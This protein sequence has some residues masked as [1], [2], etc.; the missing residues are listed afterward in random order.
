MR[1][2]GKRQ[3]RFFDLRDVECTVGGLPP[4]IYSIDVPFHTTPSRVQNYTEKGR[5]TTEARRREDPTL[6]DSTIPVYA[7]R[8]CKPVAN[9]VKPVKT[10]LPEE[11]RI[12]RRQHRDPLQGLPALPTHPP[13]FTPGERYTQERYEVQAEGMGDFLW[14]E[15]KKLAHWVIREQEGALAWDETEKG[16]FREEY[17]DPIVIPT[18]E[19]IPWVHKNIPIPPGIYDEV[20]RII[21]DKIASGVYEESNA[22]YRSRWFCVAKKD[23]KSL[24]IVHDLQ[25]LNQVTVCN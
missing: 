25:P 9:R 6:L 20:I 17:F 7:A 3:K 15:E 16:R 12:V 4:K 5:N 14:L 8:K 23:G 2:R 18:I 11:F 13:E 21:R 24:R 19:H 1:G 10:T 22:S